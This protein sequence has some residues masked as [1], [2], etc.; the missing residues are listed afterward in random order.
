MSRRILG[1]NSCQ[2]LNWSRAADAKHGYIP[3]SRMASK[4]SLTEDDIAL[5]LWKHEA[6]LWS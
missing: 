5:L 2:F 6:M 4:G 3:K 1:T